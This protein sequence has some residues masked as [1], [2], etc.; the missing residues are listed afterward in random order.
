MTLR[1]GK[2]MDMGDTMVAMEDSRIL[3]ALLS[4]QE[5][6]RYPILKTLPK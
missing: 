6:R 1:M 2:I 5:V 3:T 4:R